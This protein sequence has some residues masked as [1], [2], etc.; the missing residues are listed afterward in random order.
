ME[1]KAVE[2]ELDK[3]RLVRMPTDWTEYFKFQYTPHHIKDLH[4]RL[5][6]ANAE[7]KTSR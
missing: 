2:K 4:L 1:R 3:V 7:K 6:A 5:M